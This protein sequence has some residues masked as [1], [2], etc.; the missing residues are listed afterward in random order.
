MLA[1][2]ASAI[3][4]SNSHGHLCI[5]KD[6]IQLKVLRLERSGKQ[7]ACKGNDTNKCARVFFFDPAPKGVGSFRKSSCFHLKLSK[8]VAAS[9]FETVIIPESRLP[10]TLPPHRPNACFGTNQ[11]TN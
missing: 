6:T 11:R 2:H 1:Y 7:M 10:Q 5:G 4:L 9:H 8:N 3:M